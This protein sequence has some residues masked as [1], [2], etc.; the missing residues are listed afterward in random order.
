MRL[1]T[2][3]TAPGTYR[4]VFDAIVIGEARKIGGQYRI[5]YRDGTH[6]YSRNT[7]GVIDRA[8]D[9]VIQTILKGSEPTV[10]LEEAL[11]E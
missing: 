11:A 6:E 3:K 9:W 8:S 2:E 7:G 1:V 10:T 5:E 4:I